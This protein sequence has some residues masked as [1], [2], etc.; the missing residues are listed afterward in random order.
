MFYNTHYN[1][2]IQY[3]NGLDHQRFLVVPVGYH[4]RL[5]IYHFVTE[6]C[7]DKLYVSWGGCY[8]QSN[9]VAVYSGNL[10]LSTPVCCIKNYLETNSQLFLAVLP[11][12]TGWLQSSKLKVLLISIIFGIGIGRDK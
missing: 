11:L 9:N 7:C 8:G 5:W 1:Y 4:I 6:S 2:G 3:T 12:S 10:T